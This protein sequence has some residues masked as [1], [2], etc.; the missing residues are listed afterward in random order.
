MS[1]PTLEEQLRIYNATD[2]ELERFFKPLSPLE[3]WL[4]RNCKLLWRIIFWCWFNGQTGE[5]GF[6]LFVKHRFREWGKPTDKENN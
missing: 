5:K 2:E 6:L 4:G 1:R 3:L